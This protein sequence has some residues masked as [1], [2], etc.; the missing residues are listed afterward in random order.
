MIRQ[1]HLTLTAV[2]LIALLSG[3]QQQPA[4][5]AS[6][7]VIPS[8]SS[9][10]VPESLASASLTYA[11][12]ADV[13][14]ELLGSYAYFRDT[15]NLTDGSAGYGL[16]Q[17]RLTNKTLSSIA[18][19]GFALA[20][21]PCSVELGY[22][23][24]AQGAIQVEKTFDT[25]LSL[26]A[27]ASESYQGCFYHFLNKSTGI[28]ISDSEI[29]TIDTTLLLSGVVEAMQYYQDNTA[30]LAKGNQIWKNINFKAYED[31]TQNGGRLISMGAT[32]SHTLLS[33][34]DM[35]AEQLAMY[36]FGAGNPTE[37]YRLDKTHYD[38][39]NKPM[40][41]YA[42]QDVYYTWNGSLF[43]YQ[44]AQAYIDFEAY[45]D[46]K[47][48]NWWTNSIAA[49]LASY[50]FSVN[51]QDEYQAY[52]ENSWGLTACDT[53]EGYGGSLGA[54]PRGGGKS[55]NYASI[56][57]TMAP[58][59]ALGSILFTPNQSLSALGYYQSLSRLNDSTYGLKDSFCLGYG[60]DSLDWYDKDIIGI[61]K[62]ISALMLY[63]Y[64]S[65][66]FTQNLVMS[67]A[68]ILAGLGRLGFQKKA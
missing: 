37:S 8:D 58:T 31:R 48:K 24:S 65:P 59:G 44:Y 13:R 53:P 63:D 52:S 34:W 56:A 12:Q 61:D 9:S 29:S 43:T 33:D 2:L 1:F 14:K 67:N 4:S 5:V 3:C 46:A 50:A 62:G 16:A 6:D 26:Q 54:L 47:G 23:T 32:S 28:H 27:N 18:A 35:T 25:L 11:Q 41:T 22:L 60:Q 10:P 51:H 20:F 7:S 49:S 39:F 55:S 15:T 45:D 38:A 17:D 68:D 66:K 21:V 42:D 64:L 19:T 30:V 40:A 36:I 57:G